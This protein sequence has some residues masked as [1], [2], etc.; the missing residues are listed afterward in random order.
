M[1]T[2]NEKQKVKTEDK[3]EL[4]KI[5]FQPS[6]LKLSESTYNIETA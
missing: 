1:Q 2:E 6:L 5:P 3:K 4:D